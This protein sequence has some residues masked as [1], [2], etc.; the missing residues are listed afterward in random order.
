[1][2]ADADGFLHTLISPTEK[3]RWQWPPKFR[4][5]SAVITPL[6]GAPMEDYAAA[7]LGIRRAEFGF[8]PIAWKTLVEPMENWPSSIPEVYFIGPE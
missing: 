5:G 1:M 8:G 2:K 3:G 4:H 6:A 7:G